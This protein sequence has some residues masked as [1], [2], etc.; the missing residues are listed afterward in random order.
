M[1]TQ[2]NNKTCFAAHSYSGGMQ[3]GNFHHLSR[4]SR[5][6]YFIPWAHTGTG[7]SHSSQKKKQNPKE[8]LFGVFRGGGQVNGPGG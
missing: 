8:G 6:A 7:A 2:K 1:P 4:T 3:H 5:V